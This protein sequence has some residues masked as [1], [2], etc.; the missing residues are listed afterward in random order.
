MPGDTKTP[1]AGPAEAAMT[2]AATS[3]P[4]LVVPVD[5]VAF[6]VS[7]SDSINGTPSFSGATINYAA[8]NQTNANAYLGASATR[9]LTF[10]A[11][12]PLEAGVHLHWALPD[13]LIKGKVDDSTPLSFPVVPNRWL[14][15]RFAI[16][17][18]TITPTSF[19]V[20]SDGLATTLPAGHYA[21]VIP[22]KQLGSDLPAF[23]HMGLHAPLADYSAP[24]TERAFADATGAEL[25]AVANGMP[26]FAAFYPESRSSFGFV[27]TLDDIGGAT[28]LMYVVTGWFE[29]SVN[30]P[31]TI[32]AT[33]PPP[34]DPPKPV[35]TFESSY[36]WQPGAA[37]A[38]GD[39]APVF[40]FTLYSGTVQGIAWNPDTAYVPPPS[41]QPV[42]KADAAI[43]NTPSEALA[44]YFRNLLHPATPYFEQILTAFQ[45]GQWNKF[46]QPTPDIL[47]TIA[48]K[49]HDSQFQRVD[50]NLIWT[51]FQ[52]GPEGQEHEA[53]DLPQGIAEA[54]NQANQCR[55]DLLAVA[56]HVATFQ[57][58][59]FADWYR[60]F[61]QPN[62]SPQQS[63]VFN[64]FGTLVQIWGGTNSN[65][66]QAAWTAAQGACKTSDDALAAL[67]KQRPDL[68]L[69]EVPGPR[70][71]QPTEPNLLLAG[72]G[73][74]LSPRYGGDQEHSDSGLLACRTTD[75]LVA[76]VT[77]S[78]IT[79]N[80]GDYADA[81][82]LNSNALP[83]LAECEALLGE[84]LLLD[85][86][87][88]STWSNVAE[89]T[90]QTALQALLSGGSQSEWTINTGE[91]P[92]PVEV[93][94]WEGANPWIPLFLQWTVDFV[95]LQPTIVGMTTLENYDPAFFTAN[96]TIDAG[97]GSFLSY[98]P[99]GPQGIVID[100]AQQSFTP[101]T[102]SGQAILSD[103]SAENLETQIATWLQSHSD[104]TLST[105]LS[106]L[107]STQIVVQP[108]SGFTGALINRVLQAQVSLVAPPGADST[109]QVLTQTAAAIL[110]PSV[111]VGASL[112]D[113][114]NPIRAGFFKVSAC[115]VDAYGQKRTVDID[116]FY[117]A[118]SMTTVTAD[119]V[120]EP[121]IAYAAPRIA[122]PCRLLFDWMSAAA[123][124][125][126]EMTGHPAT[127]PVCGWL[128]PNHLTGGFFLYD[129]TGE[130]LGALQLNGATPP[131]V[132]WQ[133]APADDAT[134]DE[135]IAEALADANPLLQAVAF[136]LFNAT[137]DYFT[138]FYDAVD[139]VHATVN[140]QNLSLESGLAVLVGR[141]VALVQAALRLDLQG[142]PM[143]NQNTVCLT[144]NGWMDTENGLSG[145]EF[146]VLLGDV[147]RLDDGLI[148]FYRQA[149]TA[150]GFDLTTFFSQGAAPGATSGVVAPDAGTLQLTLTPTADDPDP[151][152][153]SETMRVLM[154]VDPR[155]PVHAVTGILPTQAL[156]IPSDVA[157][158][159]LSS[160]EI[161][162]LAA[163]VLKPSSV[164]AM[165]VPSASGFDVSFIEQLKVNGA[166][167]WVT[168]PD[169]AASTAGAVWQYTS[170]SLTEGWLRIN[171]T[172][173]T[174]DL[175]NASGKG[176]IAGG[177]TQSLTL[178]VTNAKPN[179]VTFQPG[180]LAPEGTPPK[181]SVFYIHF[182]A[183]VA[184]ADV[185]AI[186][187]S[188][189]GWSFAA[190]QD[191]IYGAYWAAT[192]TTGAPVA[193]P[194]AAS[195]KIEVAGLKAA[196]DLSQAALY[197]DYYSVDG[198]ANGVFTDTVVV[199]KPS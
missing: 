167:E 106:D 132:V 78:S 84:A 27:D 57:W 150:S 114:Y 135:P 49:L 80:A 10:E 141:P 155:A 99:T 17:G 130:P 156:S 134:I 5:I 145:V 19:V 76:S 184:A 137:R 162:F 47:A 93:N 174:F 165:P 110:G 23:L 70:Y 148:G 22:V 153:A 198:T 73:L 196:S 166:A 100:P 98:T 94:W 154:L 115:V 87:I 105:I 20:E 101:P 60:Y 89:P 24:L 164:L 125:I 144:E 4:G 180:A 123:Q 26:S 11:L 34:S 131:V 157:S 79:R 139:T 104:P 159:A 61:N 117:Q 129:G 170:Q 149:G 55:Q 90:L 12:K 194:P 63:A 140:P 168:F 152:P 71:W 31:A 191:P 195:F 122:Q 69:R 42:I 16:D 35:P 72:D 181:G 175:V 25:N 197:F 64:H 54:L 74:A 56:N 146:P 58:Q 33:P 88:A 108:L 82:R 119:G 28:Q 112:N 75:E 18:Q 182:G 102:Y 136:S 151:P 53:I 95:P 171:Q 48:E 68:S 188:A 109:A 44:A 185:P 2:T 67:V 192:P 133:G 124:S 138:A 13:A 118:E 32:I 189:P 120:T 160:L 85:T 6:C 59:V 193:L 103:K 128:M 81:T 30:D 51:I 147:D 7:E 86:T 38:S 46:S 176:V 21:P 92:S 39:P 127:S 29:S 9:P 36:G 62:F 107:Q 45:Q 163:P 169:L 65:G 97:T 3:G 77:V 15:T 178:N 96:Y 1:I 186:S 66:L 83:Y 37:P 158:A 187:L 40:A 121:G 111:T 183:L 172:Q 199:T 91:A 173:L 142:R 113:A 190:Q 41:N 143:F 50:S 116:N 43:A 52:T 14:V 179:T 177:A 126:E 8:L 161:C